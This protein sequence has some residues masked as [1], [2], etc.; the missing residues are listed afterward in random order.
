MTPTAHPSPSFG[1]RRDRGRHDVVVLHDTAMG[2]AGAALERLC[3]PGI[4]VSAHYLIA[5][6]GEV[7]QLVDEEQR[8][9][10]AGAGAWG[11]VADVNSRSIGI[12]LDNTGA[13]PFSAPLMAALEALLPDILRRW[14]IPPERVIAHSD[15]APSRKCDPGPRFDWRRLARQG[16]SVWP[17]LTGAP[18]QPPSGEKG[19]AATDER[20]FLSA[21]RRFGYR[22]AGQAPL[23]QAFRLRFRP[24]AEGPLTVQDLAAIDDLAGRFPVDRTGASA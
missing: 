5:R 21:A 10:H 11:A 2:D 6:T 9:W 8:A 13:Q 22:E 18:A 19:L 20:A 23:L 1:P 15:L 16:L 14:S 24:W 17:L 12:E 3:D 7:Y 4:E